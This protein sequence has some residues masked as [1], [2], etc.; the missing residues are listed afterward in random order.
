M[1][2]DINL[3]PTIT[4]VDGK[5]TEVSVDNIVEEFQAA[6]TEFD[7]IVGRDVNSFLSSIVPV[8]QNRS[9]IIPHVNYG[10][11]VN[12]C[13]DVF[14][15]DGEEYVLSLV[16][17]DPASLV[18]S[19]GVLTYNPTGIFTSPTEY[20][21]RGRI[22]VLSSE[23]VAASINV[24]YDGYMPDDYGA[25]INHQSFF[26]DPRNIISGKVGQSIITEV[27]AVDRI[28]SISV[29][30]ET[31][32]SGIAEEFPSGIPGS[33]PV[34]LS[35][36]VSAGGSISTPLDYA[37]VWKLDTGNFEKIALE[38][39]KIISASSFIIKTVEP[40][41]TNSNVVISL[42]SKS[43]QEIVSEL[44]LAYKNHTHDDFGNTKRINHDDLIVDKEKDYHHQY[45]RK[46]GYSNFS[47]TNRMDGDLFLSSTDT[48]NDSTNT[49]NRSNM[50]IFG[51]YAF[52]HVFYRE[53]G[54][55]GYIRLDAR[56]SNGLNILIEIP[57]EGTTGKDIIK[58]GNFAIRNSTEIGATK[59]SAHLHGGDKLFLEADNGVDVEEIEAREV[60]IKSGSK[61]VIGDVEFKATATGAEI[62][63]PVGKTIEFKGQSS[64]DG[65][66]FISAIVE[67]LIIELDKKIKF[68]TTE[69]FLQAT[70]NGA[71]FNRGVSFSDYGKIS[72]VSEDNTNALGSSNIMTVMADNEVYFIKKLSN[73]LVVDGE[74]FSFRENIAGKTRIDRVQDWPKQGINVSRVSTDSINLKDSDFT[75]RKGITF[76]GSARMYT[77]SDDTV[78]SS[79]SLILESKDEVVLLKFGDVSSDCSTKGFVGLKVGSVDINGALLVTEDSVVEGNISCNDLFTEGKIKAA[80]D[81]ITE[82]KLIAGSIKSSGDLNISGKSYLQDVKITGM[83]EVGS[84]E[85]TGN[86]SSSGDLSVGKSVSISGIL[87][88]GKGIETTGNFIT[89]DGTMSASRM[90]AKLGGFDEI[91][92]SKTASIS[93]NLTVSSIDIKGSAVIGGSMSAENG[94]FKSSLTAKSVTA[95]DA[96]LSNLVVEGLSRLKSLDLEGDLNVR[97]DAIISGGCSI[98]LD[99]IVDGKLKVHGGVTVSEEL[100]VSGRI[101]GSGGLSISGNAEMT[102]TLQS[103]SAKIGGNLD[104]TGSLNVSTGLAVIKNLE[105]VSAAD[106]NTITVKT[107]Y[108][109]GDIG[110]GVESTASIGSLFCGNL[111]IAP[112]GNTTN[113]KVISYV[114]IEAMRNVTVANIL[115]G[116]LVRA[117]S[118]FTLGEQDAGDAVYLTTEGLHFAKESSVLGVDSVTANRL[119]GRKKIEYSELA[120]FD[121]SIANGIIG[122]IQASS[123]TSADN[124]SVEGIMNVPRSLVVGGTIFFNKMVPLDP[125]AGYVD[126]VAGA[127]VYE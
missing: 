55:S 64:F 61:V 117:K 102:G 112:R 109:S 45:L 16:P 111:T 20:T 6:I 74:Q 106:F 58:S 86:I 103:G 3:N 39:F 40:L 13:T 46:D 75:K 15:V 69:E 91:A 76:G 27:S 49:L 53:S 36:Y 37:S 93:G 62:E 85:V 51:D 82:M 96:T 73:D 2:K 114:D 104:V 29:Q 41:A 116:N 52:G 87:Q 83:I 65:G 56:S 28:Y 89:Q 122:A 32:I 107:I 9:S 125:T 120:A 98:R 24:I 92:V 71:K 14:T 110:G 33:I 21:V 17:D 100:K 22:L 88:V 63:A 12:Q 77:S 72:V 25:N 95:G 10:V 81:I 121:S 79:D 30:S 119:I 31:Y 124:L 80:Q 118:V 34:G 50:L 48:S 38:D 94:A 108:L 68:G 54:E 66:T 59:T 99:C 43:L 90:L 19:T 123:F 42:L 105:V 127:A 18:I 126:L 67:E 7:T 1:Y 4:F 44:Y 26:P 8:L 57:S 70:T 78:C 115:E 23:P 84:L 35:Q 11:I 101:D 5:I 60:V 113:D 97:E 47:P